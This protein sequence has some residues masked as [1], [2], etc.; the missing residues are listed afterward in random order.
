MHFALGVERNC[1]ITSVL[2]NRGGS[3]LALDA[4]YHSACAQMTHTASACAVACSKKEQNQ[5][6]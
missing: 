1:D 2:F 6:I 4:I 5:E 3:V